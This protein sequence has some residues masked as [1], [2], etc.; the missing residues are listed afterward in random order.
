MTKD[1]HFLRGDSLHGEGRLEDALKEFTAG[2]ESGDPSCMTRLAH[3]YSL[4]EGMVRIDLDVAE[5][6]ERKA[7]SAGDLTALFN[8]AITLRNRGRVSEARQYFE[9]ALDSGDISAALELA[10]LYM[11]SPKEQDTVR[12]YLDLCLADSAL[13][14]SEQE[15]AHKLLAMV[16]F[17]HMKNWPSIA[18]AL[19]TGIVLATIAPLAWITPLVFVLFVSTIISAWVVVA[20]NPQATS[21][22]ISS[23]L[24]FRGMK[25]LAALKTSRA[26]SYLWLVAVLTV[27]FIAAVLWRTRA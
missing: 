5:F 3:M 25:P 7:G 4:G 8:L 6:W 23:W 9:L 21:N 24:L 10:K 11:V 16:G 14:E 27:G 2:A 26:T 13:L 19:S 15:E 18:A 12:K 20:N 17:S 1:E 22:S